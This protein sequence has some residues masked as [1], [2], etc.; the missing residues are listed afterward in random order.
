MSDVARLVAARDARRETD[1]IFDFWSAFGWTL[2]SCGVYSIYVSYKLVERMREHNRRRLAFLQAANAIAWERA[3][4][5]G[6]SEELRPR[7][8]RVAGDLAAMHHL[9]TQFRDPAVW[10]V[11]NVIGQGILTV[12][13]YWLLDDDL[14]KH[15]WA[16]A[17]AE[18][19]LAEL[20][21][22]LGIASLGPPAPPPRQPH[23]Y[24][25]R[26]LALVGSCGVYGLWWL[27]DLMVD[28]NRHFHRDWAWE[29]TVVAALR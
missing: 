24:V 9:T 26:V 10:A 16:E 27:Y 4:A 8:E 12:V 1:Y 20:Y 6:R 28:G 5:Q 21:S 15:A 29:D 18:W 11:L 2:L 19:Q 23:Q 22:T 14:L 3:S 7:F 13:M 25:M 17:D